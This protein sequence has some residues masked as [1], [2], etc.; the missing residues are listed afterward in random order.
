[1][2]ERIVKYT[3][4][5]LPHFFIYAKDKQESQVE[6]VGTS[7]VDRLFTA[8]VNPRINLRK[9]GLKP[10]DHS[11]LMNN[12]EVEVN[13]EVIEKYLLLNRHYKFKVGQKNEYEDKMHHISKYIKNELTTTGFSEEELADML[14]KYLYTTEKTG[15][16]KD[17]L[18][19][20][21]GKYL[22]LNL[23]RNLTV[24]E[25]KINQCVDCLDW[26]Y[27][28]ASNVKRCPVCQKKYRQSQTKGDTRKNAASS[29]MCEKT[30]KKGIQKIR[31][32]RTK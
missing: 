6:P 19:F 16:A 10:L 18:W 32:F 9:A 26:F 31:F 5:K 12:A 14:T 1:M 22:V 24:R 30:E 23:K 29:K 11:L 8:I 17:V 25:P 27:S 20:S 3:K 21:Y 28:Y 7:L 13:E 2:H 4:R 15:V